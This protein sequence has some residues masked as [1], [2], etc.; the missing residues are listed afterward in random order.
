EQWKSSCHPLLHAVGRGFHR[1]VFPTLQQFA[2]LLQRYGVRLLPPLSG[3]VQL[4]VCDEPL[5]PRAAGVRRP[6]EQGALLRSLPWPPFW[7]SWVPRRVW[8]SLRR[9]SLPGPCVPPQHEPEPPPLLAD[10][11]ALPPRPCAAR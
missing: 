3:A 11:L 8:F 2:G 1:H 7:W 9:P 6:R 5:Q 4:P 10:E